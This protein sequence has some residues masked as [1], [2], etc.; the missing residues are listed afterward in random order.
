MNV[1]I[2]RLTFLTTLA[3]LS[4]QLINPTILTQTIAQPQVRLLS[5]TGFLRSPY[6][7]YII[8]EVRNEG[9]TPVANIELQATYYD[10]ANQKITT[11][12]RR[13]MLEELLPGRKTPFIFYGPISA[14]RY[15]LILLQTY[16]PKPEGKSPA[17]EIINPL[18]DIEN[19]RL[20]GG[21]RNNGNVNAS[22]IL[23]IATFYST[24]NKVASANS[25]PGLLMAELPPGTTTDFEIALW[26]P[27]KRETFKWMTIT[28]ES[29]QFAAQQE[30]NGSF[31]GEENG[32]DTLTG[33]VIIIAVIVFVATFLI[34]RSKRKPKRLRKVPVKKTGKQNPST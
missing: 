9:N 17:L 21:I 6:Y 34:L 22:I 12:T 8:G 3:I 1:H 10:E 27:D 25:D 20:L 18:I 28:A 26:P 7:Y 11:E 2:R 23:A 14:K 32:S 13:T 30:I 19:N 15:D 5:H 24:E 4:T 29:T 16:T 33:A 31:N